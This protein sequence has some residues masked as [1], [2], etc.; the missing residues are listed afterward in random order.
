MK[1]SVDRERKLTMNFSC[2]DGKNED[3]ADHKSHVASGYNGCPSSHPVRIPQIMLETVFDT[4]LF[5][6]EEG[7]FVWAQGDP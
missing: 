3:S 7:S 5:A 2:W 6:K 1:Y 4:G